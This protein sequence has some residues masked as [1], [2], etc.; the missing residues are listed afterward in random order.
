MSFDPAAVE[1]F[2]FKRYDFDERTACARLV[3]GFDDDIEF[4]EELTFAGADLPLSPAR[5]AALDRCLRHLHLVAGVSY[6]K[7]AVPETIEVETGALSLESALFLDT[8]YLHGLG[9]F[10]YRNELDLRGR[11]RFPAEPTA[12]DRPGTLGL[13]PTWA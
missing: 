2:R 11:I 8:L 9:E 10:A 4:V 12:I 13:P 7:A 5:D 3:Y 6:Y 1:R